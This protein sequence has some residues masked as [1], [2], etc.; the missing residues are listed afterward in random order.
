MILSTQDIERARFFYDAG[1][2]RADT[3]Y[4]HL[5]KLAAQAPDRPFVRDAHRRLTRGEALRRVDAIAADLHRSGLRPGDRVS[6]WLPSR[7]ESV[8]ILLACSRM[9]YVAN[10]SLHRDYTTAE[11]AA[12]LDRAGS[13]ALFAQPGYG[14]DADRTSIEAF[15]ETL[16]RLTALRWLAPSGEPQ[17]DLPEEEVDL[18]FSTSPDRV[19]Y[20]A[21]TSGTTGLP[22]GVMHSD[23]TLLANGRAITLDWRFDEATVVYTL[24]PMSH[25]MGTVALVTV[26]TCGGELVVHAPADSDTTLRRVVETGATYLVGVPTHAIDLLVAAERAGLQRLGRVAAFQLA[27]SA[28]PS[29]VAERL[30]GLGVT[31]Q[32]TFGMTENCSFQYTR[33]DDPRD[34]IVNS[35]GRSCDGFELTIWSQEDPN[36]EVEQGEIGELGGRGACLMLGYFDD[37]KATESS[38]N[39]H[40]WFMT[41]DLGRLDAEGN[42]QIVGRKKDLIIRGGHNL[43]P[44]RIEDLA[45][46]HPAVLKTAVFPVPDPRLGEKACIAIVMRDDARIDPDELLAH[47]DREGLSR[48]DMPEYFMAMTS[49]PVTASGKVLKRALVEMVRAGDIAPLPIRWRGPAPQTKNDEGD[50]T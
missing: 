12:L 10:T 19:M 42:V 46:R 47:L 50:V 16:P 22:K 26:L 37:Q 39:I 41:G 36:R 15:R 34:V 23:N 31:P 44:A 2:W 35:C 17:D 5:R 45:M 7:V 30:I 25:N 24:S 48:Y 4:V 32:N 38:F 6:I 43:H 29:E 11:I 3:M 14:A 20:L 28:I 40:G 8:L 1:F 21:F 33:P 27:G 9:G 49:L 18:P 13:R